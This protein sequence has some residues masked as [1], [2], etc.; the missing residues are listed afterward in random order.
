MLERY[1]KKV[2]TNTKANSGMYVTN[3]ITGKAPNIMKH[4]AGLTYSF[5]GRLPLISP[6]RCSMRICDTIVDDPNTKLGLHAQ[7]AVDG[8]LRNG[9]PLKDI[10][11]DPVECC[12][13]SANIYLG[14]LYRLPCCHL[15]SLIVGL[16]PPCPLKRG[17]TCT[18]NTY[19]FW[20][21]L[22]LLFHIITV[23]NVLLSYFRKIIRC[24]FTFF[25]MQFMELTS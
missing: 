12:I 19:F 24:L 1:L 11:I 8:V 3:K 7:K 2:F 18:N 20:R 14:I 13:D 5:S 16:S 22:F 17:N 9:G 15:C 6:A 25:P 23:S 21:D 4:E 10:I